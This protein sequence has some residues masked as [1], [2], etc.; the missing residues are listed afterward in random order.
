[1]NEDQTINEQTVAQLEKFKSRFKHE[2]LKDKLE[3]FIKSIRDI[4]FE[5]TWEDFLPPSKKNPAP[6]LRSFDKYIAEIA[7]NPKGFDL[8]VKCSQNQRLRKQL[9]ESDSK[10]SFEQDPEQNAAFQL[11]K[12]YLEKGDYS[13]ASK[14][15]QESDLKGKCHQEAV[16]LLEDFFEDKD[17]GEIAKKL[18]E[19]NLIQLI[20]W[21]YPLPDMTQE[22]LEKN[23]LDALTKSVDNQSALV[24]KFPKHLQFPFTGKP[25]NNAAFQFG[26]YHLN[27]EDVAN[28]VFYFR[29]AYENDKGVVG[30]ILNEID[31][32][33]YQDSIMLNF[34]NA[35]KSLPKNTLEINQKIESLADKIQKQIVIGKRASTIQD[36]T[37]EAPSEQA[38]I[39]M[40]EKA[41]KNQQK[42]FK[43]DSVEGFLTFLSQPSEN[44]DFQLGLIAFNKGNIPEAIKHWNQAPFNAIGLS[45]ALDEIHELITKSKEDKSKENLLMIHQGELVQLFKS[46]QLS[47]PEKVDP[48]LELLNSK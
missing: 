46:W 37:K 24:S 13:E 10:L 26:K 7:K 40:L 17:I 18:G 34:L 33:S 43:S 23:E 3:V 48:I 36:F 22:N 12:I 31:K 30:D 8:L 38:A 9:N 28:A 4:K 1:M 11:G 42:R 41:A 32:H 19:D 27:R 44:A 45:A 35:L 2:G 14:V 21:A 5:L 25:E 29:T 47:N 20:T 39:D 16:E 15:W 6:Y